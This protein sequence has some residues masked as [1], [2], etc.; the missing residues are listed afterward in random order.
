MI[1]FSIVVASSD[2]ASRVDEANPFFELKIFQFSRKKK[3]Y[4]K[5]N[6]LLVVNTIRSENESP[7][8]WCEAW[9]VLYCSLEVKESERR[10][11]IIDIY[12]EK[13]RKQIIITERQKGNK[14]ECARAGATLRLRFR[15][16]LSWL[17]AIASALV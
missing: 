16:T 12:G 7:T 2:F 6:L 5:Q 9:Y 3:P 4:W 10:E 11:I 14:Q 8:N 13:N 1:Y 17:S 15:C